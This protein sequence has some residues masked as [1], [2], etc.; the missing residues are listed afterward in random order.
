M[1]LTL[2]MKITD[3]KKL[4]NIIFK[5]SALRTTGENRFADVLILLKYKV[6]TQQIVI[7]LR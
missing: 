1:N 4:I 7:I 6:V 2:L 5:L 3:I